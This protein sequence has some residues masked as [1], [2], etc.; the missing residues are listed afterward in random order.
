[1]SYDIAFRFQQALDPS[2]L[3]TLP[4]CLHALI[5]ASFFRFK[6]V[7]RPD[8]SSPRTASRVRLHIPSSQTGPTATGQFLT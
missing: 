6:L 5:A 4:A 7:A 1:M 8:Y 2:G 3:A